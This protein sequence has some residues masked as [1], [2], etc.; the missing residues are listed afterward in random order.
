VVVLLVA[1]GASDPNSSASDG[2]SWGTL[3]L[4]LLFLGM[5]RREFKKRPKA[6]DPETMPKWLSTVDRFTP[7]RS[8]ALGV[9][10]SAVNPKNLALTASAAGSIAQADLSTADTAIAVAVFVAVAS[11]TVVGSVLFYLVAPKVAEKPLAAL[12]HYM[13]HNN[14]VIMAVILVL[15]GAKLIGDGLGGV[16]S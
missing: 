5:A 7:V 2:V 13:A 6:G 16:F 11:I 4:G 12:E 10:L 14:A 15:L 1:G 8:L 9:G 3:L